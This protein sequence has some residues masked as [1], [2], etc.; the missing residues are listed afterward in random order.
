MKVINGV[1]FEP[2]KHFTGIEGW[3]K[4]NTVPYPIRYKV[5]FSMIRYALSKDSSAGPKELDY[6]PYTSLTPDTDP[7]GK[8]YPISFE[9]PRIMDGCICYD[10]NS[11]A[12]NTPLD[13]C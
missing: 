4:I 3:N 8:K 1:K 10:V 7:L 6:K 2:Y 12:T 5:R 13:C 9:N 11:G